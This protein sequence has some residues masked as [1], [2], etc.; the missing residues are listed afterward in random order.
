MIAV[1]VDHRETDVLYASLY[2]RHLDKSWQSIRPD[3][4]GEYVVMFACVFAV[5]AMRRV[6]HVCHTDINTKQQQQ[7]Q[8]QQ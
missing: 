2:A 6:H 1:T 8:Q 5:L 3:A 4:D 7:Q